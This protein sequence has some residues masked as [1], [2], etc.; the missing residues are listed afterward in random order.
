MLQKI[1]SIPKAK[2]WDY[3]IL[4]F[5]VLLAW[6]FISYGWGKLVDGQFGLR[7]EELTT[8]IQDLSLFRVSW[9]LF[10]HEPFK[11]FI[12]VSQLICGLLLLINRTVLLGAFLFLPIVA[13]I[14]IIDLSFMPPSL[15]TGFA[16][17]LSGYIILDC[18]ILW[19]YKD[20]LFIIWEAIQN[21][22]STRFKFPIWAYLLLPILAFVLEFVLA[23]PK[24]IFF[25]ITKPE[26][27][28]HAFS[29]IP[30]LIKEVFEKLF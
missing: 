22:I 13:N 15:K 20:R 24:I 2:Y 16:W 9:Y 27:T 5:R 30:A 18:L 7:P 6:T 28:L 19:H 14:L 26:A 3:L 1:K 17:R 21:K 23:I 11:T 25:L 12:G 10:D 4:V 29:Q 8:P